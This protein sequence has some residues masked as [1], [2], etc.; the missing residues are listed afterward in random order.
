MNRKDKQMRKIILSLLLTILLGSTAF[1]QG[2]YLPV[3]SGTVT[4]ANMKISAADGTSFIDFTAADVL[5]GKT[6][7]LLVVRD[8]SGRAI[9]GFIKAAGTGETL[10][11]EKLTNPSFDENTSGWTPAGATIA[12]VAGGQSN[13]C[14]EITATDGAY[15]TVNSGTTTTATYTL[16][17]QSLYIKSGTAGSVGVGMYYY[18]TSN[19]VFTQ[20]ST[21]SWQLV[22]GYATALSANRLI[23]I[24]K[25]TAATGTVLV[26]EVSTKAVLTPSATGVTITSTKGGTIFNWAQKNSAFNYNDASG[27]TYQI[28]KVLAAPIVD[29][30]PCTN[31]N[32]TINLTAGSAAW[33]C[34]GIDD[35]AYQDGKHIIAV[36]DAAG[37]AAFGYYKNSGSGAVVNAKS[38]STQNWIIIGAGFSTAGNYTRKVLYVGD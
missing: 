33:S 26:D 16:L 11:S 20:L 18:W 7:N 5:T 24:L 8:S 15:Q 1:A 22:T 38:G 27:Y 19:N 6:G 34:T 37:V 35:S 17:K 14:L 12:S 31:A 23:G 9:Q 2:I 3:A 29:S 4:Q 10:G 21:G 13:N 36:Y 30:D 32:A 28:Y 25:L